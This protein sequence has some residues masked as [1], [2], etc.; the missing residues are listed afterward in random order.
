MTTDVFIQGDSVVCGLGV[1]SEQVADA[2][3]ADALPD[4]DVARLIDGRTVPISSVDLNAHELMRESGIPES[5]NN[6]LAKIALDC[7]PHRAKDIVSA[8][9]PDRLGIVIGTSTS[10]IG[11]AG[12]AMTR[13]VKDGRWPSNFELSMQELGDPALFIARQVGAQ[14]PTYAV[15]TACTSSAKAIISAARMIKQ[16]LCDT[17]ICGGVDTVCD[18]TLN[19]F[20]VLEALSQERCKPF[21]RNRSGIHI[22]EGGA[23]FVLTAQPSA[24]RVSGWGESSDAHHISAPDPEGH[25]ARIAMSSALQM[26]GRTPDEIGYINLHGTATVQNDLMEAGAVHGLFGDTT[27]CSSTKPLTG[28]T[29]GAAGAIEAAFVAHAIKRRRLPRNRNDGEND[30][31]LANIQLLESDADFAGAAAMS[32]NYAFGGNNT[33]LVLEPT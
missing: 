18:M 26:A 23:L 2:L 21:S 9:V 1:G 14:G 5:R 28:H 22:G 27:P 25:G 19:G 11:D 32:C 15:S 8:T 7:L 12:D 10:G 16:G 30:P 3:F 4:L 17:V 29:L 33:A 24:V 6:R 13:F 20:G 31:G